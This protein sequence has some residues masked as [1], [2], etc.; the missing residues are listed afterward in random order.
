[1]PSDLI[2]SLP[3]RKAMATCHRCVYSENA[4]GRNTS[5]INF[6]RSFFGELNV[7]RGLP[8]RREHSERAASDDL[9]SRNRARA[10]HGIRPQRR[11][12]VKQDFQDRSLGN[13]SLWL[14]S[15][16]HSARTAAGQADHFRSQK[17]LQKLFCVVDV[18]SITLCRY[19]SEY[20]RARSKLDKRRR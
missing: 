11:H 2:G 18:Q 9:Q 1:M 20:S 12:T 14:H 15:L 8:S 13:W 6:S 16:H 5:N 7:D 17:S 19:D 10:R 4:V 3:E